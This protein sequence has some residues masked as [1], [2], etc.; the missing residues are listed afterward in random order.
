M[1]YEANSD[2]DGF[3]PP[4]LD[5]CLDLLKP[6]LVP[7]QNAYLV[8]TMIEEEYHEVFVIEGNS[9][10]EDRSRFRVLRIDVCAEAH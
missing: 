8:H 5:D 10:V 2:C 1:R 3:P 4:E 6:F 7:V 9:K